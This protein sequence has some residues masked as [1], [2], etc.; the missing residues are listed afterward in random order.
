MI[1][2]YKREQQKFEVMEEEICNQQKE[3]ENLRQLILSTNFM[4]QNP[5]G[6]QARSSSA[7]NQSTANSFSFGSTTSA[8][9]PSLVKTATKPLNKDLKTGL[10]AKVHQ[11]KRSDH[12]TI[13][14]VESSLHK[15]NRSADEC[16]EPKKGDQRA[17]RD[18][19]PDASKLIQST[20]DRRLPMESTQDRRL[21]SNKPKGLQTINKNVLNQKDNKYANNNKLGKPKKNEEDLIKRNAEEAIQLNDDSSM[22]GSKSNELLSRI[23]K[24]KS[25]SHKFENQENP[26]K[27]CLGINKTSKGINK[28][29]R[30]VKSALKATKSSSSMNRIH[31]L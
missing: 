25:I 29:P 27:E 23:T 4:N 17:S 7:T 26:V 8:K 13:Q 21:L 30:P 11:E 2:E 9:R 3:I 19:E 16:D 20:P 24:L 1:M 5:A 28:K 12:S 15:A 14:Q 18:K 22:A 31:L 6:Q 10:K